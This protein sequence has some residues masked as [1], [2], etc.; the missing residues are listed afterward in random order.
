MLLN[1]VIISINQCLPIA[2]LWVLLRQVVSDNR[3]SNRQSLNATILGVGLSIVYLNLIGTVSQWFDYRGLEITQM[4][5]LTALYIAMIMSVIHHNSRWPQ[6]AMVIAIVVYLSNFLTYIVGF[7][8]A[9]AMQ[10]LAIGTMLGMGICFSFSTLLY[11][12]LANAN[13]RALP[14]LLLALFALHAGSKIA[15]AADLGAQ[16]D[17][18]PTSSGVYDLRLILDEHSVV[19]RVLRA[20]M[21]YEASPGLVSLV[22]YI[23]SVLFCFFIIA[24]V[25]RRNLRSLA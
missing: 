23:G 24:S 3:I 6:F 14:M 20:L 17:L 5:M 25:Q 13:V 21:G 16:I 19:G 4:L 11:F 7:A 12:F 8:S 1:T 9:E 10:S 15:I 18:L 22:A 2:L